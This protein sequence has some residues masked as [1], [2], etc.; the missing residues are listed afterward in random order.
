MDGVDGERGA[1]GEA[2]ARLDGLLR[3]GWRDARRHAEELPKEEPSSRHSDGGK[4]A[5]RLP[6]AP[7]M[8][9]PFRRRRRGGRGR[10]V[11]ARMKMK[12]RD[13]NYPHY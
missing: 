10:R 11:T 4:M 5:G 1:A 13:K 6:T 3:D 12:T 9:R 2:A 7:P 8:P